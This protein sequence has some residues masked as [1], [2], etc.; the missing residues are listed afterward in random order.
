VK[1]L[2]RGGFNLYMRHAQSTVGQDDNLLQTTG[3]WENCA[4]QRNMSDVGREQARQVG[5]A[6]KELKI[7]VH[8]VLTAQFCRTRETGHLLGLGPIEVTE[9]IN[10]RIGQR[11]GFDIDAAR[12]RRLAAIPAGG[13][14]DLLVSH[15]HASKR[16]AE[17]VMIGLQEAEVVVYRPDGKGGAEPVARIPPTE[18]NAL[19]KAMATTK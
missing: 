6:L 5:A 13:A 18:W 15:T 11:A 17:R 16:N 7:P 14:N 9:D 2:R 12:F 4:I 3:W 1:A 19:I 8:R 10:H